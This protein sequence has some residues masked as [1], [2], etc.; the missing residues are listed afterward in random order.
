M[1]KAKKKIRFPK[2]IF[3]VTDTQYPVI[4]AVGK[5][6][7]KWRLTYELED[8]WDLCWTDNAVQTETLSRMKPYQKI[9]HFPGMY[10]LARKNYLGKGLMKMKKVFNK[11]YNFFPK[12]WMLPT[13][14]SEFRNQFVQNAK[15]K[16][17][18]KTFIVK[19]ESGCQGRGIYLVRSLEEIP[20]G[21]HCVVQAYKNKPHLIEG[22]KYDL[23]IYVLIAG[24]DPLRIYVYK[25]GLARFATEEYVPA[26]AKNLTDICMHLTNYAI[27]KN[28]DKFVFNNDENNFD[29][30]HKRSYTFV[31]RHLAALGHDIEQLQKDINAI[32]IKTL[33]SA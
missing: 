33:C 32:F 9:N 8:D 2:V 4:K 23:R 13:D 3:N 20:V 26:N 24:C 12:T 29:T 31:M 5:K 25:E 18:M 6:V 11:P 28:S 17:K 27:N 1:P 16:K 21:E 7:F 19:P 10:C 22:L 30:G 15:E 14:L